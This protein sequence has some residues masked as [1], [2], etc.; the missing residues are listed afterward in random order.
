MN[1][2][3][4][5][6][7]ASQA[8]MDTLREE[9]IRTAR[10]EQYKAQQEV[11]NQVNELR[12][13]QAWKNINIDEYILTH[14]GVKVTRD[15][16]QKV[17][18]S[19]AERLHSH[20]YLPRA[21]IK[22]LSWKDAD[23]ILTATYRQN[24]MDRCTVSQ[25]RVLVSMGIRTDLTRRQT[26]KVMKILNR[27]GK[28]PDAVLM[29]PRATSCPRVLFLETLTGHKVTGIGPVA[30]V[31]RANRLARLLGIGPENLT[32]L[33]NPDVITFLN[34][35]EDRGRAGKT[36]YKQAWKLQEQGLAYDIPYVEA[37][38]VLQAQYHALTG[39]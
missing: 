10:L 4:Y 30:E 28:I 20:V 19:Q 37:V 34:A 38:R 9:Q 39:K 27:K 6:T 35:L 14:L 8:A 13:L 7:K 16:G 31:P 23:S 2:G 32:H 17:T 11:Q 22:L 15:D 12:R 36:N 3:S 21:Y 29:R 33:S 1:T 18:R 25:M 5:V 24:K 26:E